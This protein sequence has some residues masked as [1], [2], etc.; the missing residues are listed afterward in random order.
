MV[1][2]NVATRAYLDNGEAKA[3]LDMTARQVQ[4]LSRGGQ[5]DGGQGGN[6]RASAYAEPPQAN[7][8]DIP[9]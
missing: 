3:S 9:F 8:S 2:G 7:G 5:S 4:F 6:D 1:I